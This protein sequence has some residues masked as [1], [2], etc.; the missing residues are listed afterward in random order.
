MNT[1]MEVIMCRNDKFGFSGTPFI[2]DYGIPT[3]L[4]QAVYPKETVNVY[5]YEAEK[6]YGYLTASDRI[7]IFHRDGNINVTA[8]NQEDML[9]VIANPLT[10]N[11]VNNCIILDYHFNDIIADLLNMIRMQT[12]HAV[13]KVLHPCFR[14]GAMSDGDIYSGVINGSEE[15]ISSIVSIR[16]AF[17]KH[18]MA[19]KDSQELKMMQTIYDFM[20]FLEKDRCGCRYNII[21]K[22][23][24]Y[25]IQRESGS[26]DTWYIEGTVESKES[27]AAIKWLVDQLFVRDKK[28]GEK[29]VSMETNN[30][31]KQEKH[32]CHCGNSCGHHNDKQTEIMAALRT[33]SDIC[34]EHGG[35]CES[36]CP[37]A[38]RYHDSWTCG[39]Q[40]KKP[41]Q[42]TIHSPQDWRA[43]G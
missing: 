7:R 12:P 11:I 1:N 38:V 3:E 10:I 4:I 42:I 6:L 27:T 8:N 33:I 17:L 24:G 9:I 25:L 30:V 34:K 31:E 21:K 18:E 41:H 5:L 14:L 16:N 29:Q 15:L 28:E 20:E 23:G 2:G 13:M 32:E 22:S 40:C 43:L 39:L 19:V 37:L 35:Q 36:S 26:N